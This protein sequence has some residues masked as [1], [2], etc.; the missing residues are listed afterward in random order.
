MYDHCKVIAA[1]LL[2][3]C[4]YL[5]RFPDGRILPAIR[6]TSSAGEAGL[7]LALSFQNA[8]FDHLLQLICC[9]WFA[10][11]AVVL[12]LGRHAKAVDPVSAICMCIIRRAQWAAAVGITYRAVSIVGITIEPAYGPFNG[13]CDRPPPVLILSTLLWFPYAHRHTC[14]LVSV[15][16]VISA[17]SCC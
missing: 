10:I 6:H 5:L 16:L 4:A 12:L 9:G 15:D 1:S 17:Y 11:M 14:R 7:C 8:V 3:Y 2:F 13:C